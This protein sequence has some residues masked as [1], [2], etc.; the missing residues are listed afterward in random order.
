MSAKALRFSEQ[1]HNKQT[2]LHVSHFTLQ[3]NFPKSEAGLGGH[4]FQE[5]YLA[6][7]L[8]LHKFLKDTYKVI[9]SGKSL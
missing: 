8:S 6:L 7:F 5:K 4:T 2:F 1:H 3:Y 9:S